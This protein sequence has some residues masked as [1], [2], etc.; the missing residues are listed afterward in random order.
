M[1]IFKDQNVASPSPHRKM[2]GVILHPHLPIIDQPSTTTFFLCP[3]D[4]SV[5]KGDRFNRKCKHI[6][7]LSRPFYSCHPPGVTKG[8]I[9][10]ETLRR[11][12]TNSSNLRLRKHFKTRHRN[13]GCPGRTP[14]NQLKSL[15]RKRRYHRTIKPH[16]EDTAFCNAIRMIY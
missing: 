11:L 2:T 3:K 14:L 7:N 10:G 12:R 1:R 8:S 9:N 4:T 16:K 13:K 15:I 6:T 5:Q